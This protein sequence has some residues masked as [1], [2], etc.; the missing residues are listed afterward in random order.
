MRWQELTR[1]T[2]YNK[3]K[4]ESVDIVIPKVT[5]NDRE[6]HTLGIW[7]SGGTDSSLLLYLLCKEVKDKNLNVKIQPMS[8]R[9]QRP[10]NPVKASNVVNKV[11]EILNFKNMKDHIVYYPDLSD[12]NQTELKEFTDRDKTNFETKIWDVLYDGITS[13]PPHGS[14]S[15]DTDQFDRRNPDVD[16]VVIQDDGMGMRPFFNT[17]K[18]FIADIYKQYGLINTLLPLTWSCEGESSETNGYVT[19]CESCWW[20]EEKYWAF[21]KY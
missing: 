18:Q 19:P 6:V 3:S 10:W 13:N 15:H 2:Y 20:C 9:R 14:M 7:C 1:T 8:V 12:T 4:T 11:I 21:G 17:N 16:H 5:N